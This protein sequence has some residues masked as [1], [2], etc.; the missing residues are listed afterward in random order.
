RDG[1]ACVPGGGRRRRVEAERRHP[2]SVATPHRLPGARAARAL[3]TLRSSAT[4]ISRRRRMSMRKVERVL[5]GMACVAAAAGCARSPKLPPPPPPSVVS[6][7]TE[8]QGSLVQRNMLTATAVVTRIDQDRRLVT[9]R[10]PNGKT[11]TIK[12]G[13]EVK[14]L[15]QVRRGDHVV[16]RYYESLALELKKPG[17]LEPARAV[18]GA[19]IA[20]PG[21]MPAGASVETVT[22]TARI[23]KIDRAN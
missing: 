8:G 5:M 3:R 12:V 13:D 19:G 21:Q 11:Q 7:T 14:N 10:G 16:V 15:P 4:P 1:A 2:G 17:R 18:V 6:T 20:A 23:I 9:L 22:V